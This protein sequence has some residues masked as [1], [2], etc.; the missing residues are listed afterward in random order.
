VLF[1]AEAEGGGGLGRRHGALL[2]WA[3]ASRLC[4]SRHLGRQKGPAGSVGM[5]LASRGSVFLSGW[6]QIERHRLSSPV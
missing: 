2:L 4:R 3:W 5:A 6:A 1:C